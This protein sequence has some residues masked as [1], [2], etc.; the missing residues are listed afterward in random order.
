METFLNLQGAFPSLSVS[1]SLLPFFQS[2]L[3]PKYLF[4]VTHDARDIAIEITME[5]L[6]KFELLP[7]LVFMLNGNHTPHYSVGQILRASFNFRGK[8]S[9]AFSHTKEW[10]YV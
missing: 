8:G 7:V 10:P 5:S 3:S 9:S 4:T 6:E 1:F 2:F